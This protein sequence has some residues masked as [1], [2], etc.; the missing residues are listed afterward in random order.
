MLER[1][2]LDHLLRRDRFLVFGGLTA[3]VLLSWIYLLNGAEM[4]LGA[5]GEMA[6]P[7]GARAPGY[8][9]VLF[10]MWVV[11]MAAMMLPSAAPMILFYAAIARRRRE[12]GEAATGAGVFVV[13]YLV[14]WSAFSV[15]AA[16]L[17][18]R[19]Q[20][21]ALLSATMATTSVVTSGVLLIGVGLYQLTPL[22]QACLRRC[23][24]PF[25]FVVSEWREGPRG[26]LVMGIRHGLFCVGC[27][28]A[29][30]LLLFVGGVMNLLWIGALAL[31]VLMEKLVPQGGALARAAGGILIASGAA[32]LLSLT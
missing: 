5:M 4:D 17:Q 26:A 9:L 23:R 18:W 28:W 14:I 16:I 7:M 6:M 12:R 29:L 24:S 8:L 13:G 2:A 11:M 32:V 3:A 27:C 21:A 19:L 22:K 15:G 25:D 1:T 10:V 30:M 31:L 20:A